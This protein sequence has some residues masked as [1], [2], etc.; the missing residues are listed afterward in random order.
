M[1]SEHGFTLNALWA[2]RDD[3]ELSEA[4]WK[5]SVALLMHVDDAGRCHPSVATLAKVARTS[6]SAV[7]R[8][9]A[10]LQKGIGRFSLTKV[11]RLSEAGDPDSHEYTL[12]VSKLPEGS[13]HTAPTP[14]HTGGTPAPHRAEGCALPGAGGSPTEGYKEDKGRGQGKRTLKN[15]RPALDASREP[16]LAESFGYWTETLWRQVE[17]LNAKGERIDRT[18]RQPEPTKA[19]LEH[20]RARLREGFTVADVRFVIDRIRE[21]DWHF[22]G[23]N[24]SARI[25]IEPENTIR[26]REKFES[27]L[28]RTPKKANGRGRG[29]AQPNRSGADEWRPEI[30]VL[31]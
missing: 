17:I 24:P 16:E 3:R 1:D 14:P 2:L 27:W 7:Q 30:E 10:R 9:V 4:D 6:R 5:V 8:S 22:K 26:S 23:E 19:R 20:F 18:K 25:Y 29:P 31:T 15:R 11:E 12:T 28:A 13:P 21:S